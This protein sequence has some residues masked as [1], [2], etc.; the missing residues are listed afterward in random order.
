MHCGDQRPQ[1]EE[2]LI[3][4]LKRLRACVPNG[5]QA[6][7]AQKEEPFRKSGRNIPVFFKEKVEKKIIRIYY[8]QYS[9]RILS[10]KSKP[11]RRHCDEYTTVAIFH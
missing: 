8:I 1:A 4:F 10:E 6:L 2:R 11:G 9:Y 3:L 7:F 5:T